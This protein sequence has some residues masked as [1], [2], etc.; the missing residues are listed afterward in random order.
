M[1]RL[2]WIL[3]LLLLVVSLL[4]ATPTAAR[5]DA[6]QGVSARRPS[7]VVMMVDDVGAMDDR[8]LGALPTIR[9]VFLEHGVRFTD[10]H[11]ETPICCPGRAGF[12]TGQHTPNHGVL[13]NN[14]ALFRP[15]MTLATQLDRIGYATQIP[16]YVSWPARLG[17]Q[18]REV[19]E[20]VQNIDFAPTICALVGCR[21]GPYRGGHRR[22]DG[23]SFAQ[24]LLGQVNRLSRDAVYSN[25][26]DPTSWLP[27]WHGVETTA[28]S[29]LAD[30]GCALAASGGCRWLY[31]RYQTGERELYDVSNGPCWTW[32]RGE[33][34]D[35]CRLENLAG[36][37]RYADLEHALRARLGRLMRE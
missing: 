36:K 16:F 19:T 8:L 25:Y 10:F 20:R 28:R 30:R 4:E 6:P 32:R 26:L 31:V 23:R 35:P 7:V 13:L 27:R 37:R 14:A 17:N 2:R 12:L 22:A 5:F 3:T 29:G 15:R 21:M 24:L 9:E 33:P 34:G 1:S 18:R 11:V